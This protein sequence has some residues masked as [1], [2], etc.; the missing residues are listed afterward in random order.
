M[1]TYRKHDLEQG[2]EFKILR[3]ATQQFKKPEVL[4]SVQNEEALAGWELLE[5]FDNERL[6]FKRP[7]A[8][9]KGDANLGMGID[10]YR[11][12]YGISEGKLVAY[13]ITGVMLVM[14][15]FIAVMIW[16]NP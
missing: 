3:A 2:W 12:Q 5:K 4:K 6:R 9:R 13:W 14:V 11:T 1:T 15:G 7:L 10:P 16:I 8:A